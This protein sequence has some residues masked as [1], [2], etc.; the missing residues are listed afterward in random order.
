MNTNRL[1]L[2]IV[3]GFIAGNFLFVYIKHT[4]DKVITELVAS[5][6]ALLQEFDVQKDINILQNTIVSV[7]SKIRGAVVAKN[8]IYLEGLTSQVDKVHDQL[9]KLA[10]LR[11]FD[12]TATYFIQLQDFVLKKLD[13]S[14][15]T[16]H[17]FNYYG[18]DSASKLIATQAGRKMMDSIVKYSSLLI[19]KRQSALN[20]V[21]LKIDE[22][23]S[24]IQRLNSVLTIFVI[25][26]TA[27]LFWFIISNMRKQS[28]LMKDVIASEERVKNSAQVKE[29]FL[30][31]M[32][33]EI[34]T[35]L[36]A[37][38]GFARLLSEKNLDE[39]AR[40]YVDTIEKSGG[41]L[42]A[43]VN[44]ILDISKIEAGMMRIVR[45]PFSIREVV[46]SACALYQS[47][48]KE[49]EVQFTHSVEADVPLV[50]KGDP[51]RLS[52]IMLNLIGNAWKFT[53]K[54]EVT[55]HVKEGTVENGRMNVVFE[56]HD[57]GIGMERKQLIHV[58]GR[59]QQGDE[60]ISRQY[61]GTGLGLSIVHDLVTLQGGNIHVTSEEGKGT[62]FTVSLPYELI[63]HHPQEIDK[64]GNFSLQP[65]HILLVEDNEINQQLM[66]KMLG[67]KGHTV[68]IAGNGLKALE[69]LQEKEVDV[70][71][72]DLQMPGL[73]GYATLS[74]IREQLKSRV[75]VIAVTAHSMPGE[76]EKC[77]AASMIGYISKPVNQDELFACLQQI[78]PS[79]SDGY[80]LI[81]LGY[82][83]SVSAGNTAYEKDITQDFLQQLPQELSM[84]MHAVDN[85]DVAAVKEI[86]H[87]IK[88]TISVMGLNTVLNPYL[89]SL[90]TGTPDMK[91]IA[92]DVV[93][94]SNRAIPEARH[95]LSTL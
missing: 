14:F 84:L 54:G 93:E 50:V 32:S 31:N 75:P 9:D 65:L 91:S 5:N 13:I 21:T 16:V 83:K 57:T 23:S 71:L 47:R 85:N 41:N 87:R 48:F 67:N 3:I 76:K 59:F 49:K 73:D 8:E 24:K 82:L 18:S 62:L 77:L 33:H 78:R 95:W 19:Q 68:R 79:K 92:A 55:V 63:Q 15:G 86:A 45:E 12:S 44:D 64:N 69:L 36:N 20:A 81:D 90:E 35:P 2:L 89:N 88:T 37:I 10:P 66:A 27:L 46:D 7:E 25:C 72:M 11:Q 58:F 22:D 26:Y 61:G 28:R 4:S 1:I 30:A 80:K 40:G 34:R 38:L 42:L 51:V 52:Q 56:V 70:I 94:I 29:N 74:L 60:G 43:I 53:D 17:A 39:E 6:K